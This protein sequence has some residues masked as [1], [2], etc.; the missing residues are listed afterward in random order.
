MKSVILVIISLLSSAA[1]GAQIVSGSYDV[2]S[3][4]VI[5]EVVYP[6]G[7]KE[8]EFQVRLN[9]C[10]RAVP[11]SCNAELVDMV[12]DD[13]CRGLIQKTV[14]IPAQTF[15]GTLNIDSVMIQGKNE[16]SVVIDFI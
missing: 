1:M 5:L 3:D 16:S 7:C 15:M 10:N 8:H 6:G 2:S 12:T 9:M 14:V 4:S 13:F 11:T